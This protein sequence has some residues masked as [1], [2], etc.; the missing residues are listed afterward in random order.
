MGGCLRWRWLRFCP[1]FHPH[2]NSP[3]PRLLRTRLRG[4]CLV[5]RG[6]VVT[7]PD[8]PC[9]PPHL[10]FPGP[11]LSSHF[12]ESAWSFSEAISGES[13]AAALYPAFHFLGLKSL[14]ALRAQMLRGGRPRALLSPL[15]PH[16][17]VLWIDT[18]LKQGG[19]SSPSLLSISFLFPVSASLLF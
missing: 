10:L 13:A 6:W 17:P 5:K 19:G 12:Q 18:T 2:S 8:L 1:A 11:K 14:S 4:S 16:P 7:K 15:S 9:S 3:H